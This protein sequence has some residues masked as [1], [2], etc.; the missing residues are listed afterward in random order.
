MVKFGNGPLRSHRNLKISILTKFGPSKFVPALSMPIFVFRLLN[1]HVPLVAIFCNAP[2]RSHQNPKISILTKF[3]PSK[4]IPAPSM[5]I[6]AFRLLNKHVPL[7]VENQNR[8]CGPSG[9]GQGQIQPSFVKKFQN[10][11]QLC[12]EQPEPRLPQVEATRKKGRPSLRS[13]LKNWLALLHSLK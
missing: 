6:F 12:P 3:G 4:F 9:Y 7:V 8:P 2:L 10:S 11:R 1:K 5:S 13:G